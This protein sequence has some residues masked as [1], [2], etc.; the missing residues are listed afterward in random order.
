M[1]EPPLFW[2]GGE[3]S[4]SSSYIQ[5]DQRDEIRRELQYKYFGQ[6]SPPPFSSLLNSFLFLFITSTSY[7]ISPTSSAESMTSSVVGQ[8][9]LLINCII[10]L[11]LCMC[12]PVLQCFYHLGYHEPFLVKR[13]GMKGKGNGLGLGNPHNH[14]TYLYMTNKSYHKML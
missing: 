5:N 11:P 2:G 6:N 9:V 7:D 4:F 14:Q 12:Q 3:N 8:H 10:G 1:K 13:I